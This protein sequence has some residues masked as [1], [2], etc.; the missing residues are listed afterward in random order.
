MVSL[1]NL[2][3]KIAVLTSEPKSEQ[4]AK[5]LLQTT[6]EEFNGWAGNDPKDFQKRLDIFWRNHPELWAEYQDLAKKSGLHKEHTDR[7]IQE[8]ELAR[9]RLPHHK[10]EVY[11]SAMHNVLLAILLLAPAAGASAQTPAKDAIH[12]VLPKSSWTALGGASSKEDFFKK[13][14]VFLLAKYKGQGLIFVPSIF[15]SKNPELVSLAKGVGFTEAELLKDLER[16]AL[17]SLKPIS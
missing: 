14:R 5:E 13:L 16:A 12:E 6:T 3:R 8:E 4:Q 2:M 17:G 11:A 1:A 10:Q 7:D 15:L 9:M